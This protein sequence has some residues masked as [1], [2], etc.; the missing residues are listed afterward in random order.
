MSAH[1]QSSQPR[2]LLFGHL[3]P[4]FLMDELDVL[5]DEVRQQETAATIGARDPDEGSELL[6]LE[7]VTGQSPSS[8]SRS[9]YTRCN[10]GAGAQSCAGSCPLELGVDGGDSL[11]TANALLLSCSRD[12]AHQRRALPDPDPTAATAP[13][14]RTSICAT[15]DWNRFP[16][17]RCCRP[18]FLLLQFRTAPFP[19]PRERSIL[20]SSTRSIANRR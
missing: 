14:L 19:S 5:A 12:H 6:P 20:F 9:L 17:R 2:E 7:G 16:R 11:L 8:L 10:A 3:S 15:E 13:S 1:P 18:I 4:P